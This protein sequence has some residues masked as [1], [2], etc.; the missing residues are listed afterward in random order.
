MLWNTG[1]QFKPVAPLIPQLNY[2]LSGI[3]SLLKCVGAA[4]QETDLPCQGF[5]CNFK[6]F[7]H[8]RKRMYN[9]SPHPS[10]S[11]AQVTVVFK[12]LCY[13]PEGRGFDT[14]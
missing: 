11:R 4:L 1:T 13:K 14:R 9:F 10:G 7:S 2:I 8:L 6:P 3:W 12:T 5:S